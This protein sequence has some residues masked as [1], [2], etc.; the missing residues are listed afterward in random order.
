MIHAA[1]AIR[2][3]GIRLAG[4]LVIACVLAEL[5]GGLGTKYLLDHGYKP[6]VAVVTEPYGAHHV[7]TKHAGMTNFSL[8]VKGR[9]P[10]GADVHGV[11]AIA[12]MLK[13]IAAIYDTPLTHQPWDVAGLPWL[14][15]GSI[16]GGRGEAYDLRSV[17]RNADLCTAFIAISTVPGMTAETIRAD[18]EQTLTQLKQQ[19]RGFDYT[20]GHPI[21]RKFK[22]WIVDH[23]PMEMPVDE[24]IVQM[25]AAK[26]WAITGRQPKSIGLPSSELN[27]RYGDDD[28]H[29]WG[30]GIPAPIYGPAGGSYGENFT[31]I[32][33]MLLCS[34][35]L[36]LTAMD[37][38]A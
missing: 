19:D 9:H 18:L 5:Q 10:A 28:A 7:V 13:A 38:C 30:A 32:D 27:A 36:A 33:E 24:A 4:D 20:L 11:D 26:Y 37:I 29:L 3:S 31:Y 15:V 22:T 23:P 6:D 14:K 35:V 34:Q 16:I 21:E 17:S 12:K 2:A 8:H 1:E 25:L